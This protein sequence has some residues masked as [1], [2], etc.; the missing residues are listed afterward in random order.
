M[1]AIKHYGPSGNQA[2]V[3]GLTLIAT[4]GGLLFGYDTAVISGAIGSIDANFIDPLHLPETSRAVLSGLTVASALVGCVI[5]GASAGWIGDRFGRKVGLMI[6]AALF[7]ICSIGSAAPEFGLGAIGHMGAAALV[8]FNIY[9]VIGG[10]GVGVASLLAPLYIA[11]IAPPKVRGR[12]VSFQQLA[13]VGGM[14]L[15][16]FVNYRIALHGDE[17]YLDSLGWRWMFASEAIPAVLFLSLLLL[18]PETP[19]WLV[20]KG[21]D[22]EARKIL[23]RL[24]DEAEADVVLKDIEDSLKF[25]SEPLFAF[26]ALVIFV[27]VMLSIFQQLVGINAVLYY[28]PM[29]FK[30]MGASAD[31]ALLQTVIVGVAN[32][33]FTVVAMLVVDSVGRKPLLIVGA[34]V[35]AVSMLTLGAL[36]AA[37]KMGIWSLLM[38]I[39]YIAGFAFSWGPIVWVMLAE[40]FPNPIKGQAM[41]LAVAVQWLANLGVSWS[42]KVIDSSS[43]LNALLNHGFAYLFYGVMSLLAAIFVWRFVPETKGRTLEAMQDLW[44]RRT[45]AAPTAPARSPITTAGAVH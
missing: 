21:R 13:I 25:K 34:G 28:A 37:H 4:L 27:G 24:T 6:A 29:M 36:F 9:R 22:A 2:L 15:V 42:F 19:R 41:A 1:V 38:V 3:L 39:L 18:V 45:A 31:S 11:E 8:P 35:M 17:H 16:Y 12:L 33:V 26:G 32:V 10:V 20:L 23:N 44:R 14:N 7:L 5:G 43:A 40:I 30:T